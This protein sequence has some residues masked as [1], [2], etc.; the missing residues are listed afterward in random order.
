MFKR[1]LLVAVALAFASAGCSGPYTGKAEKLS[2]PKKKKR[3]AA[4]EGAEAPSEVV[5]DEK[6][7]ANFFAEPTTRRRA[8]DAETLAKQADAILT[9][10]ER[11][12]GA[13]RIG[14]VKEA[15]SKLSNALQKDPYDPLSTYKMAVAYALVNKKG[16]AIE[17][18]K[19]LNELQKHPEVEGE[20][21]RTVKRAQGDFAF[22]AF[23]K[24]ANAAMGM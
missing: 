5:L 17:L 20:A 13:A 2:R 19:R 12:D 8:R 4:E 15:L 23:R 11:Q 7:R 24:D 21:A 18:L 6:C 22:E 3:P 10:A 14:S 16:C 9:E 1:A